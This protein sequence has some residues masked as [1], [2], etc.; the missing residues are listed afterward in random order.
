MADKTKLKSTKKL[1]LLVTI[2]KK[3][4]ADYFVD[5]IE[6]YSVNMQMVL[7]GN[8]TTKSTI[9]TDE[10][11]TKSVIL[12]IVP[13]D[14]LDKLLKTMEEKFKE[15]KGGKGVTWAVPLSSVMGVTFFNFLS[16]NKGSIL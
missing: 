6:G 4:K 1:N 15:L 8:G 7:I 5:L 12:S 3:N 13:E 11:G 14:K 9:F 16:N 10:V 2:V